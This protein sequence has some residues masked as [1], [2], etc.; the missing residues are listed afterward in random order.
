MD[1]TIVSAK[2]LCKAV[3][4]FQREKNSEFL[5]KN[6]VG[7]LLLSHFVVRQQN[8][9]LRFITYFLTTGFPQSESKCYC[10]FLG[11]D[12]LKK[13]IRSYRCEQY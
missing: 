4:T 2:T 10:T 8:R 1:Y 13:F 9:Y 5:I 7:A 3:K 12:I 11:R 6:I